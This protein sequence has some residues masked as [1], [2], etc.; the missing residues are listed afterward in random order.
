[1][2]IPISGVFDKHGF[3]LEDKVNEEE[4]NEQEEDI[5]GLFRLV[6]IDQKRINEEKEKMNMDETSL[7]NTWDQEPRDWL[8][9]EVYLILFFSNNRLY[10]VLYYRTKY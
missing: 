2:R 5:G 1:M 4:E 9:E 7:F 3:Q 8:D 10:Y 6:T